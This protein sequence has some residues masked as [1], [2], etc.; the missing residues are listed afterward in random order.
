MS[1]DE[2]I[3]L[4]VAVASLGSVAVSLLVNLRLAKTSKRVDELKDDVGLVQDGVGKVGEKVQEVHLVVNS[5]LTQLLERTEKLAFALGQ[6]AGR[7]AS[8]A[9]ARVGKEKES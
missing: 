4:L 9:D 7:A 2:P 8:S 6:A 5:R 3:R 1:W